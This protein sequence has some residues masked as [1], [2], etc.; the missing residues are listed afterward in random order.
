VILLDDHSTDGTTE[1]AVTA[2][3]A[4]PRFRVISGQELPS[5]WTGKNWACQQL[6][7]AAAG[8]YLLFVDADVSLAA[9]TFDCLFGWLAH[10]NADL[11]TVFPTQIT[12]TW[13]ER[14][15][16]PLMTMVVVGYL[17]LPM[18]HCSS[19][20]LFAA[21][22]GQFMCFRRSAYKQIGGHA[23]VKAQIIEDVVLARRI[24]ACGL[25]LRIADGQGVVKCRMY[26]NWQEV[27][28]GFAK[29]ILAGHGNS[30][31]FLLASTMFHWLCFV[32]PVMWLIVSPTTAPVLLTVLAIGLRML[33]AAVGRQRLLD[34]LLLPI[35]VLLITMIAVRSIWW[36][37]RYGGAKWKDRVIVT[38]R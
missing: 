14:L 2:A 32:F 22:N 28:D 21:A 26:H 8:E 4:A 11:L 38:A 23:A 6:A 33:S 20:P 7:E 13:A 27:C 19:I 34:A 37:W 31:P 36:R 35:S 25:R 16:V 3:N 9:N 15:I 12:K 18:A 30:V 1:L 10:T 29:N 5:G 17:P 24:K